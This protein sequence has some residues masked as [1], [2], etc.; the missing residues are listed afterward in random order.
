MSG[1]AR[2]PVGVL[3]VRFWTD[4]DG[5][6]WRARITKTIDVGRAEF[7]SAPAAA[8]ADGVCQVV[9]EWIEDC[10]TARTGDRDGD[11]KEGEAT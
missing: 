10:L 9:Q 8:T 3:I 2:S 4:G 5:S 1:Q 7:S 6:D 11:R